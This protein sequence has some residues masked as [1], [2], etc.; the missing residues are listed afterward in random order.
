MGLSG[1]LP[2][3]DP[4]NSSNFQNPWYGPFPRSVCSLA[5]KHFN[6]ISSRIMSGKT[7]VTMK[8][9]FT[10]SDGLFGPSQLTPGII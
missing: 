7:P 10:R 4:S 6:N 8:N 3:R 5:W 2:P 1:N 9:P